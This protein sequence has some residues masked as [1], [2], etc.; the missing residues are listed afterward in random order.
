[1]ASGDLRSRFH[2]RPLDVRLPYV[3]VLVIVIGADGESYGPQMRELYLHMAPEYIQC[4][5]RATLLC[6]DAADPL[7]YR[8]LE[9]VSVLCLLFHERRPISVHRRD[10]SSRTFAIFHQREIELT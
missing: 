3:G 1:M 4:P 10:R 5:L 8:Y 2:G 7:F 6:C 9:H